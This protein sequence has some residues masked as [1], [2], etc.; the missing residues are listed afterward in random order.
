MS[1]LCFDHL[2]HFHSLLC[3]FHLF[4]Q[5]AKQFYMNAEGKY[6]PCEEYPNCPHCPMVLSDSPPTGRD[7]LGK[8]EVCPHCGA[9][10]MNLYDIET[11]HL[12]V[13]HLNFFHTL[14]S[15]PPPDMLPNLLFFRRCQ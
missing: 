7:G 5:V 2:I 8:G 10:R 12:E 4:F 6:L 15:L 13:G 14:L 11:D 3:S 1:S 9:I